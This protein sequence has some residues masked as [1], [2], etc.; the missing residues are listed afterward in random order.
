MMNG[1]TPWENVKPMSKPESMMA[2]AGLD[3]KKC[4]ADLAG[5]IR[6]LLNPNRN[7]RIP[8]NAIFA[9]PW[10]V[11]MKADYNFRAGKEILSDD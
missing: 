1:T 9:D 8:V 7:A 5:L 4:S 6:K 3:L 10:V 11:S 2:L